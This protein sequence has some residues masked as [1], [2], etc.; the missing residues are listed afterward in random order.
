MLT[1]SFELLNSITLLMIIVSTLLDEG[2][3]IRDTQLASR[4][5]ALEQ[6]GRVLRS[7]RGEHVKTRERENVRVN[8]KR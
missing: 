5:F 3:T 6:L 2:I 8:I 1:F 4:A 7:R